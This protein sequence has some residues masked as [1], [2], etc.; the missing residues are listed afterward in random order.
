MIEVCE[1]HSSGNDGLRQQWKSMWW[2]MA[3]ASRLSPRGVAVAAGND[4]S[5]GC[6]CGIDSPGAVAASEPS[7]F[8]EYGGYCLGNRCLG[9]V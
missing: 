2:M 3:G 1:Y 7:G 6:P 5:G 4:G 8:W 9:P